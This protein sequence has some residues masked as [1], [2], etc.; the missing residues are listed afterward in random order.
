MFKEP[1]LAATAGSYQHKVHVIHHGR[2]V[3]RS[4]ARP[5]TQAGKTAASFARSSPGSTAVAEA[6]GRLAADVPLPCQLNIAGLHRVADE[7]AVESIVST[8][9]DEISRGSADGE[10]NARR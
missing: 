6:L 10:L 3:L 8:L 9:L 7:F 2:H 1:E 5:I 4:C